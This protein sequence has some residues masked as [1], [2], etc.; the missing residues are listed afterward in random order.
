MRRHL[1]ASLLF[2]LLPSLAWRGAPL[3]AAEATSVQLYTAAEQVDLVRLL[4]PPPDEAETHKELAHMLR[5]Q[6]HR[7][8]AEAAA[9]IADSTISVFRFAD[10]LGDQFTP[11][12]VPKTA[13]FFERVWDSAD[14]PVEKAKEHWGR[15]RPPLVDHRIKPCD[16]LPKSASYPS[17]HSTAGNLMACL[18]ADMV[19][20]HSAEL[21]ARGRIFGDRRVL[22]GV[23]YPSDVD[24][25][26]LCATA[27]AEAL[28]EDPG[29]RAD[30]DDAKAELR[31]ALGLKP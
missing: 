13:A 17:G 24:A 2:L 31:G 18:L 28:Y 22:G 10:V 29:F 20:E 3:R 4:P 6:E 21:Y 23:H 19:P 9:C 30:F 5:M 14:I 16:K 26:R 12:A 11:Q 1:L 27:I 7:S 8:P 15:L 25:G